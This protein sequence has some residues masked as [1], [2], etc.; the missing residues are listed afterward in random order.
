MD[1]SAEAEGAISCESHRSE[2]FR[3]GN[4]GNNF[5]WSPFQFDKY[6]ASREASRIEEELGEWKKNLPRAEDCLKDNTGVTTES[7]AKHCLLPFN[8]H[9]KQTGCSEDT[10]ALFV[11]YHEQ[12][13]EKTH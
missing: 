6:A 11:P 12:V 9:V 4:F 13:C 3:K 8:T 10:S 2:K 5:I 1:L 7:T